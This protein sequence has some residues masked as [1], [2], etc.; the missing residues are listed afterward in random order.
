MFVAHHVRAHMPTRLVMASKT[1]ERNSSRPSDEPGTKG[2]ATGTPGKHS[3]AL[4]TP[5]KPSRPGDLAKVSRLSRLDELAH[6]PARRAKA[7][8]ALPRHAR[9]TAA[10]EEAG[11]LVHIA[12]RVTLEHTAGTREHRRLQ[13]RLTDAVVLHD[14]QLEDADRR[15]A[16]FLSDADGY[17]SN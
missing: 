16:G 5:A 7:A 14:E 13:A 4:S 3:D 2:T 17:E 9:I 10:A 15:L 8:R 12:R 6:T 1:D 11:L